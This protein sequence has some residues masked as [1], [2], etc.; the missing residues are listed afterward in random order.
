MYEQST[1]ETTMRNR[2]LDSAK[3]LPSEITPYERYISRRALLAGSLGFA[4]LQGMGGV[5]DEA[6]GQPA[7]ALTYTRNAALSVTEAPNSYQ[8]ITTY[9][10]YYEFG[11]D[12]SDPSQ[13]ARELS[14][15]A[16]ERHHR[17]RG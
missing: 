8:D 17:R 14:H 1:L 11:T 16:V 6:F 2:S 15:P 9:N 12:K 3:I 5:A 10:N 4:A 13:N 7:A